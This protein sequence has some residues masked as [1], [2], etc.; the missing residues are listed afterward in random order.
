MNKIIV[1]NYN[2]WKEL[3]KNLPSILSLRSRI[4]ES[5][6]TTFNFNLKIGCE[7]SLLTYPIKKIFSIYKNI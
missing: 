2:V 5:N 1:R 6:P 4:L 7:R 3:F